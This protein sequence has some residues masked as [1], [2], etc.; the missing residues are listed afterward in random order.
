[1]GFN[2]DLFDLEPKKVVAVA[3]PEDEEAQIQKILNSGGMNKAGTLFNLGTIV[4]NSKVLLEAH[5]RNKVQLKEA[6]VVKEK[7]RLAA[8]NEKLE[9]ACTQFNLWNA[10]GSR[11]DAESGYLIM[12][13]KCAL[14]IVKV[15]LP[16]I[17]PTGKLSD[18]TTMKVCT[19]WLG[20]LA[21][22]TTWTVELSRECRFVSCRPEH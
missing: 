6:Q 14:S 4:V 3:L 7:A 21:G 11:V 16:K 18:Y 19:K 22:C 8:I 2:A 10:A 1:M 15:L 17:D 12:T 9:V 5:R 20:E 13:S